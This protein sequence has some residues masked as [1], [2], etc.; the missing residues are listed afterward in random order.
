MLYFN[1]III[2][3]AIVYIHFD[4]WDTYLERHRKTTYGGGIRSGKKNAASVKC[5]MVLS[6]G[7]RRKTQRLFRQALN[8][9]V[10][11]DNMV[12]ATFI[13]AKYGPVFPCDQ[14]A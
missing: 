5:S 8:D 6:F 14:S 1:S 11:G 4:L 13:L 12:S 2:T 9:I 10:F 7:Y 3:V